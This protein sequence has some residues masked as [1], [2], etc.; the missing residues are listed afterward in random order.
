MMERDINL[1]QKGKKRW[2]WLETSY[3]KNAGYGGNGD[4]DE[5]NEITEDT[6]CK[7][8][9]LLSLAEEDTK[10]ILNVFCYFDHLCRECNICHTNNWRFRGDCHRA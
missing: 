4:E 8:G 10:D 9:L 5:I 6:V 7:F 1:D 3:L 2:N